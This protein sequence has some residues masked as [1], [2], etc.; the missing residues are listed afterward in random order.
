MS[1][2]LQTETTFDIHALTKQIVASLYDRKA[3]NIVVFDVTGR[4]SYCDRL[5]LCSGTSGR[6]IRSLAENV[7]AVMKA[8]GSHPLGTEGLGSGHWVLVDLGAIIVHVFD[9][10]S[11]QHYDL[12]GMWEDADRISLSELGIVEDAPSGEIAPFLS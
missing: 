5:I 3:T 7:S 6:Q 10:E 4:T 9:E 12:D 2:S 1:H 8:T 11:R